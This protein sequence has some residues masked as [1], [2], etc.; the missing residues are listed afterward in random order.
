MEY[1]VLDSI[2]PI[3][4]EWDELAARTGASPFARPGWFGVWWNAFGRG[5]L[6]VATLRRHGRLA[7]VAPLYR[8]RGT[9]LAVANV[10]S[11]H[12]GP[13]AEDAQAERELAGRIFGS[14]PLHTSLCYVD[15]ATPGYRTLER[16]A[17]AAR[18][19]L[20]TVTMQRSP[21]VETNG[22]W[23]E[24]EAGLSAKFVRDL[25]RRRRQLD[26]E[27]DVVIEIADGSERLPELLAEAFRLEPS[28]WKEKRGTAIVSNA[29]TRRFYGELAEWAAAEGW[30]RLAF[31][32]L[33]GRPLAFQY[34]L[35]HNGRWYFLKGGVDPSERRYA[36]GK[37]LAHA[38]IERAFEQGLDSF[39]F[40]GADEHWKSDWQP[41]YRELVLQHTFVRTPLGLGW[42]S[43]IKTWRLVGLPIAKRTLGWAR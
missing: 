4:A 31:L 37:I 35:E 3:A 18:R 32:R 19:R 34:V 23:E 25:R 15:A 33:D 30:L 8:H 5:R 38:M 27:G 17:Q 13:L 14:N 20:F 16:S 7:A 22:S 11:P 42:G 6:H 36:P 41:A 21:F 28:G 9:L 2:E 40:L 24:F 26:A 39:E 29:K 43:V 12:F 10:H 1:H